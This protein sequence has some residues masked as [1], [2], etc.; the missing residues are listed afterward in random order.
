MKQTPAYL[1][2]EQ[3]IRKRMQTGEL[4][5]GTR[6]PTE[7]AMCRRYRVSRATL[8]KS[9]RILTEEGRLFAVPGR[10]TFVAD[11]DDPQVNAMKRRRS[12]VRRSAKT[13][14]ALIPCITL[15]H[16]PQIVRGIEDECARHGFQLALGNFDTDLAKEAEYLRAFRETGVR[17]VVATPHYESHKNAEYKRLQE[18][19]IP[20]VLAD[21][22]IQGIEAD[23]VSTDN[24]KG[25][26]EG[27][28]RLIEAGCRKIAFVSGWM[29]ASTS[30]DRFAGFRAAMQEAGLSIDE[31]LVHEGAFSIEF[32]HQ[33]WLGSLARRKPDAVFSA[34]DPISTGLLRAMAESGGGRA[35]APVLASF[36]QPEL[37]FLF[38]CELIVVEQPRYE[39]GVEAC[40]LLMERIREAESGEL[41]TTLNQTR[42]SRLRRI[43]LSPGIR[44]LRPQDQPQAAVA[45]D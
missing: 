9:L 5:P 36:D 30:Q 8:R 11:P 15:A 26:E 45:N 43:L 22:P 27:T 31:R 6:L 14:A 29:V 34:N 20:L 44:H 24:V 10:G 2:I 33:L 42:A 38:P 39:M 28:R 19:G 18:R 3:D 12:E 7:H 21:S 16:Y 13:V 1:G 40:R 32:G 23:L 25:A 17:G 35:R 41:D 37:P 4:K